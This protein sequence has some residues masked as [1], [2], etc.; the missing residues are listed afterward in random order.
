MF[1]NLPLLFKQMVYFSSIT[2]ILA[3]VGLVG[4][5]GM[6]NVETRMVAV[7]KT[8]PLIMAAMEMKLEVARDL[9][10]FKSLEAAQWPDEV[11]AAVKEHEAI[12]RTFGALGSAILNGGETAAGTVAAATDQRLQ[13]VVDDALTFYN[14][15]FNAK[16][17]LL[18]DLITKKISAEPY[19]YALLDEL[20]AEASQ[21][22]ETIIARLKDVE[23]SVMASTAAVNRGA[24]EAIAKA[25]TSM[26]VGIAGGV[27]LALL[28][29]VVSSRNITRPIKQVVELAQTMSGGDFTRTLQ[30]VRKDE[31]G[32]LID[33]LNRLVVRMEQMLRQVVNS[34]ETLRFS[35][36]EMS[37]L[38]DGMAKGAD[39]TAEKSNTV[40]GA[41]DEINASMNSI[42]GASEQST[43]NVARVADV[44]ADTTRTIQ[45]IAGQ[46]Q[47][48]RGIADSAVAQA[49]QAMEKM[50]ALGSAAGAINKVTEVITEIS[51]QTNLLALNATIEAARAGEAGKGFAVVANE[52]KELAKQTAE[53]THDIKAKI[54]GI[55]DSTDETVAGMKQIARVIDQVNRIVDDIAGAVETQLATTEAVAGNIQEVSTGFGEINRSMVQCTQVTG[56]IT[57]EIGDVKSS[58]GGLTR[59]GIEVA[60]NVK[61]L[62]GLAGRLHEMV[63]HFT[64]NPPRF[65]IAAVKKAHLAWVEKL[66]GAI[67]GR[68][69]I[70]PEEMVDHRHC[71][72]GRWYHSAQGQALADL[73]AYADA[74]RYHEEVHRLAREI[75][76]LADRGDKDQIDPL[77]RRFHE[78]R[79]ALFSELDSLYCA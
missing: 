19:D 75:A 5:F 16:F 63:E 54:E 6:H 27:L 59:T 49:D 48:A 43:A 1:K 25:Q 51:E 32:Q 37:R 13:Q 42:S 15:S 57:E 65:D 23:T 52:I 8:G 14:G 17:K 29:G 55:Q 9:Q 71:Q 35:S 47:K 36:T 3:I 26:L 39:F 18:A 73:P 12:A 78:T 79:M 30:V 62:T 7:T 28:L 31:I 60:A 64:V 72:L 45:E 70:A 10:L 41:A 77:M 44:I 56:R 4:L 38:T 76:E 34:V 61:E 66:N 20:G 24:R 40:A 21:I 74:G 11:D 22:G 33:A 67:A 53:A 50:N 69:P 46:S 68:A 58:A 2:L